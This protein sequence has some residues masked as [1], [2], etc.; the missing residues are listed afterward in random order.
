LGNP[1]AARVSFAAVSAVRAAVVQF[2]HSAGAKAQNFS[3]I[4]SF[5]GRLYLH[6]AA[7]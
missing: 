1:K 2:E 3:K 6:L 5:A 4:E 7:L